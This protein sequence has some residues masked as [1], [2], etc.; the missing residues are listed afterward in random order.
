MTETKTIGVYVSLWKEQVL[1]QIKIKLGDNYKKKLPYYAINE[2][3]IYASPM[4]LFEIDDSLANDLNKIS[5]GKRTREIEF[6]FSMFDENRIRQM[7]NDKVKLCK[8]INI[9]SYFNVIKNAYYEYVK[10]FGLEFTNF[11][12]SYVCFHCNEEFDVEDD[13]EIHERFSHKMK[14]V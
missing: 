10:N 2:P 5:L 12:I 13:L 14:L 7:Y 9:F 4:K 11:K 8:P 1:D 6:E 3:P